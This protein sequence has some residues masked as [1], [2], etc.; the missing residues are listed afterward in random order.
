[1]GAM[2]PNNNT[3]HSLSTNGL[4]TAKANSATGINMIVG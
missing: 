4:T 1:M 2:I 3:N